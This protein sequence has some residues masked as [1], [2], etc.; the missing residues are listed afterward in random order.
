LE[1]F[2]D[3]FDD[4]SRREKKSKGKKSGLLK[5]VTK[6]GCFHHLAASPRHVI[7]LGKPSILFFWYCFVAGVLHFLSAGFEVG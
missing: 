7:P 6:K 2:F 1:S 4:T 5:V 3:R